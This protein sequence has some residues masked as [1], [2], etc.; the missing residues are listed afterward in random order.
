M[1]TGMI[2]IRFHGV[3][4]QG[5]VIASKILAVAAFNEG[6]YPQSFPAFGLERRGAPVMAFSRIDDRK[7]LLRTAI[8]E[9]DM[10][11]V[12]EPALL[13][14]QDITQGLKKGGAVLISTTSAPS[15]YKSLGPFRIATVDAQGIA[16]A[17]G[18]GTPDKPYREY[19]HTRCAFS[20]YRLRK[21]RIRH[22]SHPR[23][24]SIPAGEER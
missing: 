17:C 16:V 18:L 24:N 11:V 9:P 15:A 14:T 22:K 19:C 10:V 23:R 7:I 12:L 2:E 13:N 20:L 1:E 6:K 8:Y 4:G 21:A 3:G 5:A